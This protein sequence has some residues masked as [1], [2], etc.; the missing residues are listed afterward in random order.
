MKLTELNASHIETSGSSSFLVEAWI[1]QKRNPFAA[2]RNP[3]IRPAEQH[4]AKALLFM[5]LARFHDGTEEKPA[6]VFVD[7]G[8]PRMK[9]IGQ[10]LGFT[11][12]YKSLDGAPFQRLTLPGS[13]VDDECSEAQAILYENVRKARTWPVFRESTE[14][15][16]YISS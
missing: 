11:G 13:G 15:S 5:H 4:F 14:G 2:L 16:T 12:T 6:T 9:M 1:M 10:R 3:L 8:V 7:M